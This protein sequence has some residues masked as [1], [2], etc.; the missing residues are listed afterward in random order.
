[1][2]NSVKLPVYRPSTW[3]Y[4]PCKGCGAVRVALAKI[5]QAAVKP[6]KRRSCH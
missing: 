5:V 3:P 1:M 6:V 2:A 4:R